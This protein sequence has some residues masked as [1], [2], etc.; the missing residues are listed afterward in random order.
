MSS[1][2]ALGTWLFAILA[3]SGLGIGCGGDEDAG[4]PQITPHQNPVSFGNFAVDAP[5]QEFEVILLNTGGGTLEITGV[6]VNGDVNCALDPAP[7]FSDSLP[8]RL[9]EGEDTFL[10]LSYIPG[11][12]ANGTAGTKDQISVAVTS[13]SSTFPVMEIS[14][15]GCILDHEPNPDTDPLCECNLEEV[16]DADCGG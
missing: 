6:E 15:C 8:I 11:G 12:S 13:N 3:T 10:A 7:V 4:P 16:A 1:G 9:A 14:V 2:K 5:V